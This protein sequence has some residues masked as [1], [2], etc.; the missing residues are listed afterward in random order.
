MVATVPASPRLRWAQQLERFPQDVV[1]DTLELLLRTNPAE[2]DRLQRE[3]VR[4]LELDG[5][6]FFDKIIGGIGKAVGKVGKAFNRALGP[7]APVAAVGAN[8][9]PGFGPAI[10]AGLSTVSAAGGAYEA[11]QQ[12]ALANGQL[13]ASL[14]ANL[15]GVNVAGVPTQLAPHPLSA[16]AAQGG[17]FNLG[18]FLTNAGSIFGSVAGPLLSAY[19]PQIGVQAPQQFPLGLPAGA[20][21]QTALG[22]YY[23][24]QASTVVGPANKQALNKQR[25]LNKQLQNTNR[26]LRLANARAGDQTQL[27]ANQNAQLQQA[28]A[29]PGLSPVV[30][31][32]G[33]ALAV[34]LLTR[35][36][37]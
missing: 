34:W 2:F 23:P 13:P 32:G 11:S 15:P 10:S 27:L 33:A 20:Y 17:G 25:E 24:G 1:D 14:L 35:S 37:R 28:A 22:P 19:G 5:L 21:G 16:Q 29:A 30:L 8:L 3:V 9:I 31:I 6:G 12:A 7:V 4:Q 26:E 36:K 18:N